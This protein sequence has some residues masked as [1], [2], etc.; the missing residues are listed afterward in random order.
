MSQGEIT[1]LAWELQQIEGIQRQNPESGA[2]I[3]GSMLRNYSN[4]LFGSP[5]QLLNSVDRRFDIINPETGTEYLRNFLLHAPILHIQ[6]GMPKYTGGE[7]GNIA[8]AIRDVWMTARSDS[9][10]GA[11]ANILLSL[12]KPTIFGAGGKLQ[13]RMFSFQETYMEYTMFANYMCRTVAVLLG[14]SHTNDNVPNGT[15]ITAGAGGG[16]AFEEFSKIR[17]ENY[18][19]TTGA[20]GSFVNT[21]RG[22]LGDLIRSG[23][24]GSGWI[25]SIINRTLIDSEGTRVGFMNPFNAELTTLAELDGL[26]A[27]NWTV[28]Q[29]NSNIYKTMLNRIKSVLFM[30]EPVSFS[31][32]L[33]N[34]TAPSFIETMLDGIKDQFGSEIAFITNSGAD[35]GLVGDLVGFLGNGLET[36]STQLAGLT[37]PV[38]GGFMAN[39]FSGAVKSLKGQ[40]ML[41]PDIYKSSN[42]VFDYE[43]KVRLSSPYGDPYNYYMNIIVPLMHLIALAA[44]RLITSNSISSPFLVRSYIPGM[45]SC[46]LGIVS[47]MNITKNP[48]GD[49]VSVHGFPLTVDVSFT[50]KE[51]YNAMAISPA[52]DPGSFLFNDTLNDYLSTAAGL[53]PSMDTYVR[54]RE[55][56]LRATNSY[57]TE[58]TWL[59]DLLA[60]PVAGI[61]NFFG[62]LAR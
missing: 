26:V 37:T 14:I 42:S 47:T 40:K 32:S 29:T 25:S 8:R 36:A 2:N 24:P 10:M 58:M 9:S 34:E 17:W 35:T 20:A 43:Y 49:H 45:C 16:I 41:Y 27:D 56:Q 11:A 19:M 13:K 39:I 7:G 50:I 3:S 53:V 46:P 60:R 4:R 57:F 59:D 12:A 44:P 61:E 22:H 52:N 55:A 5:F 30:V 6:P 28:A 18:R 51:L 54:M 62:G 31:E 21:I 1:R 38:T 15:F 33:T 23:I 48:D